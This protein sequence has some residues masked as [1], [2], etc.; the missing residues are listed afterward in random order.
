MIVLFLL[1]ATQKPQTVH[2]T[3]KDLYVQARE[4]YYELQEDLQREHEAAGQA[5]ERAQIAEL[6]L[7]ELR[8]NLHEIR[9]KVKE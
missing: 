8:A 7:E 4:Q 6:Q 5:L 2:L 9:E 1:M 3:Y